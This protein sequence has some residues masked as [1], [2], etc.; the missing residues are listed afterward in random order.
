[1]SAQFKSGDVVRMKSG[2]PK[3]TVAWCDYEFEGASQQTAFCEWF[4]GAKPL[5]RKFAAS[6]LKLC[7]DDAE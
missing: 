2:G 3:M 7:D 5:G 4:E 1:M 6:T